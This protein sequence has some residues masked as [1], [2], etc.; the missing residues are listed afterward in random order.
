M[1]CCFVGSYFINKSW[2]WGFDILGVYN[3]II[4][5]AIIIIFKFGF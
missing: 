5:V 3:G 1:A 4:I 2:G